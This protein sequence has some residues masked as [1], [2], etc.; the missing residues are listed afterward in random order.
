MQITRTI[1]QG[2]LALCTDDC[3]RDNEAAVHATRA[4]A[5]KP[6]PHKDVAPACVSVIVDRYGNVDCKC[7]L[8]HEKLRERHVGAGWMGGQRPSRRM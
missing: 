1:L 2:I 5:S 6:H 3:T 8:K 7:R 4:A